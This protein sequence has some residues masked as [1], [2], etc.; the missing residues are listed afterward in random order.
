[1]VNCELFRR[2]YDVE[3]LLLQ[4]HW[5]AAA[6]IANSRASYVSANA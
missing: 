2:N 6:A 4:Y 3:Q 1:M 5:T